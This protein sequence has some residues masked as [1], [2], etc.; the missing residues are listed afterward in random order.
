MKN[1]AEKKSVDDTEFYA[2]IEITPTKEYWEYEKEKNDKS[3]DFPSDGEPSAEETEQAILPY[4]KARKEAKSTSK[5]E[6]EPIELINKSIQDLKESEKS[7][8]TSEEESESESP[9]EAAIRKVVSYRM[10]PKQALSYYKL[11]AK[12]TKIIFIY[13]LLIKFFSG[14]VWL[15]IGRV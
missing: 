7:R 10:T 6:S 8:N 11:T 14:I 13:T 2:P 4:K 12:V 5:N 1:K 3:L 15:F 9:L